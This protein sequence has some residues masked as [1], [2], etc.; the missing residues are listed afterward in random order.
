MMVVADLAGGD[1][2]AM[3]DALEK[4]VGASA[5]CRLTMVRRES[6]VPIPAA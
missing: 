4:S 3:E 6:A 5:R 2:G 1:A